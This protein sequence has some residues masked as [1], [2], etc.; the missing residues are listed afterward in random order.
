MGLEFVRRGVVYFSIFL[1]QSHLMGLTGTVSILSWEEVYCRVPALGGYLELSWRIYSYSCGTAHLY[2]KTLNSLHPVA[3]S[4]TIQC[5]LH[6]A[7]SCNIIYNESI[8]ANEY[9]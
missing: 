9:N 4:A 1:S 3:H 8:S 2:K 7:K 6:N 5:A